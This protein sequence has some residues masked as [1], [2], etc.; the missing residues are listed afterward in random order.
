LRLASPW[1]IAQAPPRDLARNNARDRAVSAE[2][3]YNRQM[4]AVLRCIRSIETRATEIGHESE[5]RDA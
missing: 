5:G 3:L 1:T 2:R 4:G